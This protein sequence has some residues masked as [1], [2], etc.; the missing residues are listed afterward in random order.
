MK[1]C[2]RGGEIGNLGFC[3]KVCGNCFLMFLMMIF[4]AYLATFLNKKWKET[5]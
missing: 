5:L 1:G 3:R 4:K 2:G